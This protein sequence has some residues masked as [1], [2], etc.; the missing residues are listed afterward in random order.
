MS[1]G[2]NIMLSVPMAG[3][4]MGHSREFVVTVYWRIHP[5]GKRDDEAAL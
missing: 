1:T 3:C 5:M 2:S 4:H